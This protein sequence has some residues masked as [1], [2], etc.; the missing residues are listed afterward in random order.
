[1]WNWALALAWLALGSAGCVSADHESAKQRPLTIYKA[2]CVEPATNTSP[3]SINNLY[4]CENRS[5]F[6]PYQ[7][8]T[9]ADWDGNKDAPCRHG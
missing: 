1:M 8:W 9:G 5:L 7:L 6:I 4:D 2:A 3:W